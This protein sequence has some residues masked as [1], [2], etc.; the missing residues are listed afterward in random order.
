MK[1]GDHPEFYRFPPPPGRSRESHIVLDARG[2]FRNE[3]V[4]IQHPGMARAF[5]SWVRRHP[6]DGRYILSNDYDWTYLTVEDTPFFVR[7]IDMRAGEPWLTLTDG[8]EEPLDPA[9]VTA[10]EGDAV[11][12]RVRGGEFEARL[13]PGAQSALVAVL[14]EDADGNPAVQGRDGIY[15]IGERQKKDQ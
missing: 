4:P 11:Y 10:G 13:L 12:V 2:V 6:H 1:P 7:S 9:S 8:S 3:G 5:A 15:S 14:V